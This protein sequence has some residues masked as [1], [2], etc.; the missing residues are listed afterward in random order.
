[1]KQALTSLRTAMNRGGVAPEI[2]EIL[3]KLREFDNNVTNINLEIGDVVRTPDGI[4]R[5]Q[6][7]DVETGL[8]TQEDGT[9]LNIDFESMQ[10]EEMDC[11][12]TLW[13]IL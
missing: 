7:Q 12:P 3:E 1:M 9:S 10:K 4:Q 2:L 13:N 5:Y 11:H 8:V 6:V